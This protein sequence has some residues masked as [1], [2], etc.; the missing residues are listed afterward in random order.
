MDAALTLAQ[1]ALTHATTSV[2]PE[3]GPLIPFAMIKAED[4][5]SLHRF[6]TE[7]LEEGAAAARA[8]VR[9]SPDC[10]C[11]AVAWDGY[12]TTDGKRMDAVFVEASE[13]GASQ[14]MVFAQRYAPKGILRKKFEAVGEPMFAGYEEPLF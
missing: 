14:S 13:R 8:H 12:A 4:G 5:T 11:A 7:T 6:M 9:E 10:L 1:F 2:V 3:G